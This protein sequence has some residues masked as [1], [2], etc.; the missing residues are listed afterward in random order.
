MIRRG[1]GT[2]RVADPRWRSRQ[3]EWHFC[4]SVRA[5]ARANALQ[6]D[7]FLLTTGIH[8]RAHCHLLSHQDQPEIT[9][10]LGNCWQ[11]LYYAHYQVSMVLL[12]RSLTRR[13]LTY[14][15]GQNTRMSIF[16]QHFPN[17]RKKQNVDIVLRTESSE[18]FEYPW[19]SLE[20]FGSYWETQH[21]LI[22]VNSP[23]LG[24]IFLG[25]S[26]CSVFQSAERECL[27]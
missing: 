1:P 2:E 25:S 16:F 15:Y 22:N 23:W 4:S 27:R 14:T 18:F 11:L 21:D 13:S 5:W 26:A 10:N 6:P 19:Q 7:S 12:T 20:L 17:R 24:S 9:T 3:P 8:K